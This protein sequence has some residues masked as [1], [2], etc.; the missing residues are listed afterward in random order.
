[1][2][3]T[4]CTS[5]AIVVK[6]GANVS[7][8]ASTSGAILEQYSNEAEGRLCAETRY[9]WIAN[10]SRIKANFKPILDDAT[11]AYAAALLIAYDQDGYIGTS[12]TDLINVN[13]DRFQKIV[14][15]LQID[16]NKTAMGADNQ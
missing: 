7:T 6:A 15:F 12:G 14:K 8:T 9:D 4:L 16:E 1:M 13:M 10:Y 11:S 3:F 2:S 5:G